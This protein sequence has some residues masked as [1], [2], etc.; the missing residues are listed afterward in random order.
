MVATE[1]FT[2]QV[3][4]VA[5][6]KVTSSL[7]ANFLK[8]NNMS[9]GVPSRFI[10]N[11]GT[12]FLNKDVRHLT[13]WYSIAHTTSTPYYPKENGQAK[14]SNKRLL[15]IL[16]KITKENE[17]GWRKELPTTLR[18]H[19]TTK[20]QAIGASPF[21]LV[22]DTEAIILIDLVRPAV[23]LE[24]IVGIPREDILEVVDTAFST[25]YDS[26]PCSP[27]ILAPCV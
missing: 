12:S 11:N 6:K 17:K 14:A 27:N 22:Y 19:R 1:L 9:F 13:E 7:V 4:A 16:G 24:E 3:K 18:A 20:S 25:P 10:S 5:M 2:K 23:K 8:K 26:S 15:K 21:S